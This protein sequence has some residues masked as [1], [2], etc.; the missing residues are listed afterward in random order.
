MKYLLLPLLLAACAMPPPPMAGC[1]AG[2]PAVTAQLFFGRG[3]KSGGTVSDVAWQEFLA[4]SVTPR[5]PD[6]LTV[7]NGYGQWRDRST[8]H[9]SHE[10][11]TVVEI[12]TDDSP[13]TL[14]KLQ[15][16]RGDYRAAFQQESVG[17][18]LNESC[19]SF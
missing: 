11:S 13:E 2:E 10:P 7:L 19:A 12:V 1:P 9:I 5:F 16:I 17:L 4:K 18:V 15:A 3:L 14:A 8:S 6:G